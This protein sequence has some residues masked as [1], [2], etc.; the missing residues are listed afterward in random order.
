MVTEKFV[1]Q[2]AWIA[3]LSSPVLL[4]MQLF[5][6]YGILQEAQANLNYYVGIQGYFCLKRCVS[7]MSQP[8]LVN[9]SIGRFS[10]CRK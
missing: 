8:K 1:C 4:V 3:L 5:S 7:D 10:R 6:H 9:S 2:Y